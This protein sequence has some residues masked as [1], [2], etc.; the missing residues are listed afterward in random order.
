M[1]TYKN[2]G[3]LYN[4][5]YFRGN[6]Q[7][8]FNFGDLKSENNKA[9][10]EGKNKAL[11]SSQIDQLN[12]QT[13]FN[14]SQSFQLET[15]YPGLF[16]GSG[17]AHESSQEGE[18]KLGFFFD[19]TSGMP[20]IPGSSVKGV[21]RSACRHIDYVK[22]IIN[23]LSNGDRVSNFKE[24]FRTINTD[25]VDKIFV[26]KIFGNEKSEEGIYSRDIFL[27]AFPV[28]KK[29]KLL[30]N[31][32]I[33]PHLEPLKNPVPIQFMKVMPEVVFEFRFLLVDTDILTKELKLELFRQILLDQGI[34]AKTNVGYGQFTLTD[35][36][37]KRL[38]IEAA[39]RKQEELKKKIA[40]RE[41]Q[42]SEADKRVVAGARLKCMVK[43]KD[44]KFTFFEFEWDP[45]LEVKKKTSKL[46]GDFNVGEMVVITIIED[47]NGSEVKF[48][49]TIEKP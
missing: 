47:Y 19:Y 1:E 25:L 32:F 14:N 27:D 10:L 37:R 40:E 28:S 16:S 22:E 29:G 9:I 44:K 45:K 4:R 13:H 41:A 35:A 33:T 6:N 12:A 7:F 11:F 34:G 3:L 26:E 5:H 36:E 38:E 24:E 23:E 42:K 48:G 43:Q 8:D 39:K 20:C 18:L 21:L 46:K 31:D 30:E 17:Y 15:I 49:N 2:I